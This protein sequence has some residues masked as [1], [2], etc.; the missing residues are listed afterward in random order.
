MTHNN[1]ALEYFKKEAT[2]LKNIDNPFVLKCL[3]FFELELKNY[4]S[5]I[6]P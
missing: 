1:Q 5:K 3:E 4:D 2:F 6:Y